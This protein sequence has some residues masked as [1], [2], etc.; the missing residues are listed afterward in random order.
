MTDDIIIEPYP[1]HRDTDLRVRIL[2]CSNF[3]LVDSRRLRDVADAFH[4]YAEQED[5]Q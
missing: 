4:D 2:G 5:P 3:W 1:K